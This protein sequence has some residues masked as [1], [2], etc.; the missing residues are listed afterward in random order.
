[1]IAVW[2][3]IKGVCEHIEPAEDP[4]FVDRI[5]FGHLQIKDGMRE[6]VCSSLADAVHYVCLLY[7]S[8]CV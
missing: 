4:G 1:M 3:R 5:V 2:T 6:R 8:R 7:T